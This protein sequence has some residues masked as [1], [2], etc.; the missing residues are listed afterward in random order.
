MIN[1]E[2]SWKFCDANQ[3]QDKL[4]INLGRELHP[5]CDRKNSNRVPEKKSFNPPC[6]TSNVF[7][8]LKVIKIVLKY[9]KE[10][11]S[12]SHLH[13]LCHTLHSNSTGRIIR[14]ENRKWKAHAC[15]HGY[16][17]T[18]KDSKDQF[19]VILVRISLSFSSS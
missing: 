3:C 9:E 18:K 11:K 15:V 19:L 1:T 4:C 5:L 12:T 17:D 6:I 10:T 14:L 8:I 7:P 13:A 16:K 2:K